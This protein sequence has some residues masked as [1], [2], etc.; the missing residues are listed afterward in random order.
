M[1]DV[2]DSRGLCL[3]VKE[4]CWDVRGRRL[5]VLLDRPHPK[6][7]HVALYMTHLTQVPEFLCYIQAASDLHYF[8][9]VNPFLDIHVDLCR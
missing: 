6:A 2:F 7:G 3:C 8:R 4:M 5:A 1:V 9:C